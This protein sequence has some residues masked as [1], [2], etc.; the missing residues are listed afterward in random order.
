MS[1]RML[2]HGGEVIDGT[3]KARRRADVL[4]EDGRISAVAAITPSPDMPTMDVTGAVVFPG[5]VDVHAHDDLAL[6]RSGGVEPKVMQGV[7]T[8]VVGNCGHGCAPVAVDPHAQA[9]HS[10]PILGH[11]PESVP[12][13][14]FP[15]YLD[16][17]STSGLRTNAVALVPHGALRASIVG[18]ARRPLDTHELAR[19]VRDLDEA[20]DHGA[21]GLSLGL[22]Y[23]PGDVAD[24]AE[25]VALARVV[26]AHDRILAAHIR[27]EGD[28][29]VGSLRELLDIARQSGVRVQLSHLKVVSPRN[30]GRMREVLDVLDG[31]R[32]EGIDI[33]AD[34]YPY[35]AGSTTA[36]AL[37]PTW[38]LAEGVRGLLSLLDTPSDRSRIVES[39][40]RP[41]QRQE[42]NFLALGAH[43]VLLSGFRQPENADYEGVLLSEIAADRG[44]DA[45]ECLCQLMCEERGE[46]TVVM[47]QID[48][49]DVT[50][51][52][53]W[54][55]SLIGSDGL[56]IQQPYTHPRMYGTFARVLSE[57]VRERRLFSLEEATRRMATLPAERFG[58]PGRGVIRS[59]AAADLV[60][61]APEHIEDHATFANPR[62]FPEHIHAVVVNGAFAMTN[63]LATQSTA[64]SL[65]PIE[66]SPIA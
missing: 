33:T 13:R 59:G 18:Y 11:F 54:P 6:L 23:A 34:V 19:A 36:A 10:G 56:P 60:V 32:S 1:D 16:H 29:V 15:G 38:T 52:L 27:S 43:R 48:E 28:D 12:W 39:L 24:H 45:A 46:I 8:N 66:K 40:H 65:L 21:A 57:Y 64:G 14:D 35:T 41:W 25:L 22:M 30:R 17:L 63:G 31:A 20:L 51:A 37:F 47:F 53:S 61:V 3:G 44:V 58:I 50:A 42:N 62:R 55:W 5:F 2:L 9:S 7:T 4:V 26:A 49:E